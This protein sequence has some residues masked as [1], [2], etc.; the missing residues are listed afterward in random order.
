MK[1]SEI[2]S[3]WQRYPCGDMQVGGI[4]RYRNDYEA[5]F[6]EYDNFRYSKESHIIRCLDKIN[7]KN[8]DTLEIGLGQ[9]ADSEQIIRRGAI[10]SGIDLT[11]ESVERV[12]V[13]FALRELPYKELKQGSV[14][15]LPFDNNSFDIVF[16]HGVLHHVPN[17]NKAQNEIHRVLKPAGE[18]IVMLYA[19]M[20]LNY[21]LS[22][23]ILRR[24]G[25]IILY[26]SNYD[27][28]GIYSQ[29][30]VNAHNIGL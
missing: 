15:D 17:I 14:L 26:F 5:F 6:K 4:Q 23:S 29:H 10:W 18:L 27:L 7:F 19:K 25:L 30:L 9:G 12:K 2:Q 16:S 22:I 13:R 24:L 8:R 1:E 3:F 21:L 11:N 20:S 28:G